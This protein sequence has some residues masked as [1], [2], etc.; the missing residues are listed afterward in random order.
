MDV[1]E[2]KIRVLRSLGYEGAL[3][4]MTLAWLQSDPAVSAVKLRQAWSQWL[5]ARGQVEGLPDERWFFY[6]GAQGYTGS[7][8]DRERQ[9]WETL[10]EKTD[11]AQ[12]ETDDLPGVNLTP[13]R[14]GRIAC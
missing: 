4:D 3:H 2:T 14:P 11:A 6:L 9:F 8:A 10:G 1:I 13:D 5:A 7:L 12:L